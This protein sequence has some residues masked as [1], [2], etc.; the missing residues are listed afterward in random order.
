MNLLRQEDVSDA[1]AYRVAAALREQGLRGPIR[2]VDRGDPVDP[3]VPTLAIMLREWRVDRLG[4]VD[5]VFTA[6]LETPG[7]ARNLGAFNG[8]AMMRWSRPSWY[9]RQQDFE[10][11]AQDALSNLGRRIMDTGLLPDIGSR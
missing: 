3:Q 10:D 9:D 6:N 8:T 11:A 4:N 7:G 1:F 5:C 2:Y